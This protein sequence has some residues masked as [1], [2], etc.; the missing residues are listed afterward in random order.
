MA[1]GALE[2]NLVIAV[3]FAVADRV[4]TAKERVKSFFHGVGEKVTDARAAL[5]INGDEQEWYERETKVLDPQLL[6]AVKK[7]YVVEPP[8]RAVAASRDPWSNQ[9][10][11]SASGTG[12]G[13]QGESY[14]D[15][16][17]VQAH[18]LGCWG[19]RVNRF[20]PDYA[21]W[22]A[23][24]QRRQ[25]T[26]TSVDCREKKDE[27]GTAATSAAS[28]GRAESEH[29]GSPSFKERVEEERRADRNVT[30]SCPTPRQPNVRGTRGPP[31]GKPKNA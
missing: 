16:A 1:K 25:A 5:A 20:S 21:T 28:T 11:G 6:S 12:R 18:A 14:E 29:D 9:V 13:G 19:V 15:E 24:M 7:R 26:G 2:S 4:R 17:L 31:K 22:R 27:W 8:A 10:G 23:R 30:A 3:G